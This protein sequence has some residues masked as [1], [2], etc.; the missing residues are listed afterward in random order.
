MPSSVFKRVGAGLREP[1]EADRDTLW[2]PL[3]LLL[4]ACSDGDSGRVMELP[5]LLVGVEGNGFAVMLDCA[6]SM[7][8]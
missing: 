4:P 2:P 3:L 6:L 1:C 8:L 7:E 5:R